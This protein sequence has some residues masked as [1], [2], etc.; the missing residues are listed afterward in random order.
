[1]VIVVAKQPPV[2]ML[3]L[4]ADR[5]FG[6]SPSDAQMVEITG[7]TAKPV[8]DIAYGLALGPDAS[9]TK[10]HRYQMRPAGIAFWCLSVWRVKT[11][12]LNENRSSL[13]MI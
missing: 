13:E 7:S 12:L 6:R 2:A 10:E 9:G 5:G 11:N 3:V 1:M 8:A 4:I